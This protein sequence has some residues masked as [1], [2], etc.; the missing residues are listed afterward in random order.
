[1]DQG[2]ERRSHWLKKGSISKGGKVARNIE[3]FRGD[4]ENCL[5]CKEPNMAGNKVLAHV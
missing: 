2:G 4:K 5:L 3:S 1:M